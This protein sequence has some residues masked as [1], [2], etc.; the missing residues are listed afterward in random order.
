MKKRLKTQSDIIND[1]DQYFTKISAPGFDPTTVDLEAAD[2]TRI[3]AK[4]TAAKSALNGRAAAAETKK[5]KTGD[6]SGPGGALDQ[7]LAEKRFQ[8]NVIRLSDA[9]DAACLDLGVDRRKAS[10]TPKTI[11]SDPPE[12]TLDGLLPGI[13]QL[14]ARDNGSASPRAR[15]RNASGIQVAIVDGTTTLTDGEAN[16]APTRYSSRS[17]WE[18]SS[19]G[20]PA[21]VRLYARWQTQTGMVSAWSLPLMVT[22][23]PG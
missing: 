22:V 5:S 7:L 4:L 10:P 11:T 20:M 9:T 19:D 3:G 21:K 18:I 17:P 13:I 15:T 2:V 1:A 23:M 12:F 14:R 6:L 16:K 8:A